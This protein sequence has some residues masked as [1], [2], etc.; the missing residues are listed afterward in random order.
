[1]MNIYLQVGNFKVYGYAISL[2]LNPNRISSHGCS[3]H[4]IVR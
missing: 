4:L 1:M 3:W 2:T